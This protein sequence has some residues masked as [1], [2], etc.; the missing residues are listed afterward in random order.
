MILTL[1]ADLPSRIDEPAIAS[2]IVRGALQDAASLRP[3][4]VSIREVW[5]HELLVGL[6]GDRGF[7]QVA[8]S[9]GGPYW[10]TFN[11]E[12]LPESG[13]QGVD[14]FLHGEHHTPVP[15]QHLVP[16]SDLWKALEAFLV[17]AVRSPRVEW[18]TV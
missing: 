4:I 13:I 3:L 15:V 8:S 10:V 12:A 11:R 6:E 1:A 16:S 2:R 14:F 9:A 17:A 18:R 5:G 7:I